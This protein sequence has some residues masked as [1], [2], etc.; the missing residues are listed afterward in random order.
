[1]LKL[2]KR[3]IDLPILLKQLKQESGATMDELAE[4]TGYSKD[5]LYKIMQERKD[6]AEI[7]QAIKLLGIFLLNTAKDIPLL[8]N[9]YEF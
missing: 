1:M 7:Q 8:G 9:H 3:E 4:A 6:G 2:P 5:Y